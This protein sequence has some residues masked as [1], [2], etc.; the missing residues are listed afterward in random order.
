MLL[1]STQ[2]VLRG[3]GGRTSGGRWDYGLKVGRR[4]F[5]NARGAQHSDQMKLV[6]VCEVDGTPPASF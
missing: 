5:P 3:S 6:P 1:C 4:T 2:V